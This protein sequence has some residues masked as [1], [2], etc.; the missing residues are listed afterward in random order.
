MK[1][2]L[3]SVIIDVGV[4]ALAASTSYAK[5]PK[6]GNKTTPKSDPVEDYL[7]QHDKNHDGVIDSKEFPGGADAFK[8][9]DKNGD[10]KLDKKELGE[11]LGHHKR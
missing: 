4:F 10:G 7:K 2:I 6:G 8:K 1:S 9:A 3:K 5:A 11:M